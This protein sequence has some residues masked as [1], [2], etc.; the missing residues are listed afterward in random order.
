[1]SPSISV[2]FGFCIFTLWGRSRCF[3]PG[4][5]GVDSLE[6]F[7]GE[8]LIESLITL[9]TGVSSFSDVGKVASGKD[10]FTDK[11]FVEVVESLVEVLIDVL[12]PLLER[13]VFVFD[14]VFSLFDEEWC[15]LSLLCLC[16]SLLLRSWCDESF[17]SRCRWELWWC[18]SLSRCLSLLLCSWRS[19]SLFD[20]SLCLSLWCLSLYFDFSFSL[21]LCLYLSL[22]SWLLIFSEVEE[23]L[24]LSKSI[25]YF[26]LSAAFE[27]WLEDFKGVLCDLCATGFCGWS[28]HFSLSSLSS[29]L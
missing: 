6:A 26:T 29:K 19:L 7:T 21:S 2:D 5:A 17:L 3:F 28:A 12:L 18:L 24:N 15:F 27:S 13:F 20:L 25:L 22:S 11:G 1:M 4:V 10:W 16:L 9:F 23:E 8:L 14:S